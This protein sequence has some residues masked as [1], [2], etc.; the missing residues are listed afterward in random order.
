MNQ[1]GDTVW[2]GLSFLRKHGDMY[3]EILH[4]VLP[5]MQAMTNFSDVIF[6]QDGAPP[7]YAT[8]VCGFSQCNIP[9]GRLGG[10]GVLNGCPIPQT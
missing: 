2:A 6:Q 1:L 3:L 9:R 8:H 7:H 10:V 5:T 4:K